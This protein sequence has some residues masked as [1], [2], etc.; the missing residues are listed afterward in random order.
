MDV[1]KQPFYYEI[2]FGFFD[3]KKQADA[4]EEMIKKFS[5]IRVERFLD[6]ACGPSLQLRELARRGYGGRA[7]AWG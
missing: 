7:L 1:Y 3:V 4:F 2:A 5:K 6:A